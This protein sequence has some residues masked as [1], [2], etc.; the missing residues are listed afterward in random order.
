MDLMI[1]WR[2]SDYAAAIPGI[3]P[4]GIR[5]ALLG[6]ARV[7]ARDSD[8]VMLGESVLKRVSQK[9]PELVE[10][11]RFRATVNSPTTPA[12]HDRT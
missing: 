2:T 9:V 4:N 6:Y 5:H 11:R 1:A 7:S 10:D 12:K 8:L 3:V